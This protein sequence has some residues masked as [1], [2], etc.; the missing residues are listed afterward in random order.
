MRITSAIHS[1]WYMVTIVLIKCIH[2][3][4][5]YCLTNFYTYEVY[6]LGSEITAENK[7]DNNP[8]APRAYTLV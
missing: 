4:N 8:Y 3:F 6:T 2:S 7:R 1:I 5:K